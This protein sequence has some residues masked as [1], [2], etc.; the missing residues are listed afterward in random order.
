MAE[1]GAQSQGSRH[2]SKFSFF[3]R[4]TKPGEAV[5]IFWVAAAQRPRR[6]ETH[7]FNFT[8]SFKTM[9]YMNKTPEL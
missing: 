5:Q 4:R 1:L 2:T 8:C 6:E 9:N 3:S 7:L